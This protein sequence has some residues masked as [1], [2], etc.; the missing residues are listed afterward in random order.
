MDNIS[1]LSNCL[2]LKKHCNEKVYHNADRLL[3]LYKKVNWR[4]S[5]SLHEMEE[6]CQNIGNKHLKQAINELLDMDTEM[7][8]LNLDE[9]LES[10]SVSYQIIEI[11]NRS[12]VMLKEYPNYGEQYFDIINK[13]YILGYPCT[14]SEI[15][16]DLHIGR[17]TYYK[18]KKTAISMLGVILWGFVIPELK[19]TAVN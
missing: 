3:R 19:N 7:D 13:M 18:Y 4:L 2:D 5:H 8:S 11:I 16:D 9:R 10:I 15:L 1:V 17:T 14:E 6:D 12:L